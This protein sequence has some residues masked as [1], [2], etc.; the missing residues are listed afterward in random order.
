MER[1]KKHVACSNCGEEFEGTWKLS[2]LGF[3]RFSCPKCNTKFYFPLRSGYRVFYLIMV[4]LLVCSALGIISRIAEGEI[5]IPI[6]G[7]PGIIG[8]L[9]IYALTK[10]SSLR[11]KQ[12]KI[13][14][15]EKA[16]KTEA[17]GTIHKEETQ[18]SLQEPLK[19]HRGGSILTLGIIGVVG[20]IVMS[21]VASVPG[22][23]F[24]A[25]FFIICCYVL[26]IIALVM[27]NKDLREMDAGIMDPS[28]RGLTKAGRIC[29]K[30]SIYML[31]ICLTIAVITVIYIR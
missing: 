7:I 13:S 28:G 11:K 16:D 20:P 5:G 17:L 3:P 2:A 19:P 23:N 1:P 24:I 4:I 26:G 30:V 21:P 29:G 8:I 25:A 10:D 9:G 12:P 22:G 15:V 18:P 27:G 14:V 6:L 31:V